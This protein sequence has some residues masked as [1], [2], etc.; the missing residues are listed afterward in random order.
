LGIRN[1]LQLGERKGY[2]T[3]MTKLFDQA[4]EAVR[5]LPPDAQDDIA[6]IILQL[7]GG[8]TAPVTLSV[9]ERAA[10]ARSKAAAER[11]E[12]ATDEQVRATWERHGL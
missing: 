5:S 10:I 2:L 3:I 6:R 4:I 7:A 8:D 11:G 9:E 1:S 12:F